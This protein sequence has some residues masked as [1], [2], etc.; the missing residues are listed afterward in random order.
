MRFL[1]RYAGGR[2]AA[3]LARAI[4]AKAARIR[5]HRPKYG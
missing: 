5:A 2:P 4:V 3:G 1:H